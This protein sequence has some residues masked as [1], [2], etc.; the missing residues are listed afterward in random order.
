MPLWQNSEKRSWWIQNKVASASYFVILNFSGQNFVNGPEG[1]RVV[2]EFPLLAKA[3]VY[4]SVHPIFGFWF[5]VTF[6]DEVMKIQKYY[7]I[8]IYILQG[9]MSQTENNEKKIMQPKWPKYQK[10][11]DE[12]MEWKKHLPIVR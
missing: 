5:L 8:F 4:R 7:I 10:P 9:E 2:Q 3:A 12:N 1:K 11:K 6:V